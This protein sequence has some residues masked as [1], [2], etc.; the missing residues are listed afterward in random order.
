MY[1][2]IFWLLKN[3]PIWT[4]CIFYFLAMLCQVTLWLLLYHVTK[5]H[6]PHFRV[7]GNYTGSPTRLS[8]RWKWHW[9]PPEFKTI[10]I[11]LSFSANSPL[12]QWGRLDIIAVWAASLVMTRFTR[13]TLTAS[14]E[15][16]QTESR[17]TRLWSRRPFR[18]EDIGWGLTQ[19]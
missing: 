13:R 18:L 19:S 14:A 5:Y 16:F 8:S 7:T 1:W 2:L 11:K 10:P 15:G 17:A 3:S 12:A 6:L 9:H 4:K